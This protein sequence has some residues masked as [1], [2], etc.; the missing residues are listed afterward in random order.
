MIYQVRASASMCGAVYDCTNDMN[1]SISAG[2][3]SYWFIKILYLPILINY[4]Y[5]I[6]YICQYRYIPITDMI[7]LVI[8]K[9]FVDVYY[10]KFHFYKSQFYS[11]ITNLVLNSFWTFQKF[12]AHCAHF[13]AQFSISAR[14][15]YKL[16]YLPILIT[17][18]RY[19]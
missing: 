10:C 15:Q 6:L 17:D 7:D 5:K 19:L 14:Y 18:N 13:C 12:L 1:F 2:T 11:K 3:D 8:Y 4:G 16:L 9:F